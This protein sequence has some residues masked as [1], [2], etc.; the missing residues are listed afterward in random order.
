[1]FGIF[2]HSN[3]QCLTVNAQSLMSQPLGDVLSKHRLCTLCMNFS[4]KVTRSPMNPQWVHWKFHF[5]P[6]DRSSQ[7]SR[8]LIPELYVALLVIIRNPPMHLLA[9]GVTST[10]NWHIRQAGKG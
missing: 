5:H 9:Q 2:W 6:N 3:D 8:H 7:S 4:F 1:M 10:L